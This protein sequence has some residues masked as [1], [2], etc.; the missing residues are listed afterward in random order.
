[1]RHQ[2]PVVLK[3]SLESEANDTN[4]ETPSA[5]VPQHETSGEVSDH[6]DG[7]GSHDVT[8]SDNE[9]RNHVE[10]VKRRF[11]DRSKNY[12][13]PQLERLYTRVMKGIFGIKDRGMEDDPRASILRYLSNFTEDEAN[14]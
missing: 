10:S 8:V 14:F 2:D 3:T 7:N 5:D 1:M 9:I 12:D 11:V 13:I 4:P 6:T